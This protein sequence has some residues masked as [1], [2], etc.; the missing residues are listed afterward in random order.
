MKKDFLKC[1]KVLVVAFILLAVYSCDDDPYVEFDYTL[2][3]T[4]EL[5]QYVTPI[6]TYKDNNGV[7][8]TF[9]IEESK[10]D[11]PS[12]TSN[13]TVVINGD[14]I[15]YN[16]VW[17]KTTNYND[18]TEV[19]DELTVRYKLKDGVTEDMLPAI[20]SFGHR[21]SVQIELKDKDNDMHAFAASANKSSFGSL[22]RILDAV[23]YFGFKAMNNGQI[24]Q[25]EYKE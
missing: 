16:K 17:K 8:V 4:D 14:T 24:E 25:K 11:I 6:V 12:K 15:K 23:D 1:A 18:F 5:L 10:W 7:T 22:S 21:L 20:S 2:Q 9:D 3:C 19:E 13:F